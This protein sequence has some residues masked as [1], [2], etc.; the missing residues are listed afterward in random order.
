MNYIH[1]ILLLLAFALV[2][3]SGDGDAQDI[4]NGDVTDP[5]TA[6]NNMGI[7]QK[8]N[9]RP[10]HDKETLKEMLP[11]RLLGMERENIS[12]NSMGAAGFNM[13]TA[14]ATYRDVNSRRRITVTV[15]DGMGGNQAAMGMVNS[16]TMDSEEGSRSTKT[17]QVDGHKAIRSFDTQTMEGTLSV[18][19]DQSIVQIEGRSLEDMDELEDAYDELSL[20]DL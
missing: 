15:S 19:Y 12:S 16:L 8:K 7:L 14:T 2:A 10:I 20:G 18:V 11:D 17:I 9:D 1:G 5:V 3:C 4:G 13:S 6:A